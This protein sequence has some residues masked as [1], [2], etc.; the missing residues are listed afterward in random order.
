MTWSFTDYAHTVHAFTLPSNPLWTSGPARPCFYSNMN[1]CYPI[2]YTLI[3]SLFLLSDI[4]Q[5]CLT[6]CLFGGNCAC[7]SFQALVTRMQAGRHPV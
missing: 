4:A 2:P 5:S 1:T 6:S 7:S 3:P